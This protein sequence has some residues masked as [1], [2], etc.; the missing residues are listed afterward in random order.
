MDKT[1]RLLRSRVWFPGMDKAVENSIQRCRACSLTA[2]PTPPEPIASTPFPKRQ[3]DRLAIDFHGP[4]ANGHELMAIIDEATKFPIVVEV[5]STAFQ[6]IKPRLDDLFSLMGYPSTIKSDNGPPFMGHDF[7]DYLTN[8]G[9]KHRKIT[10]YH[11]QANGQVEN[12]N[13]NLKKIIQRSFVSN[14]DWHEELNAFL[15]GYRATPHDSTGV[16][17]ADLIFINPNHSKLPPKF[18]SH[19]ADDLLALAA[20]NDTATK[21]KAKLYADK[22]RRSRRHELA[23]GDKVVIDQRRG[24]KLYNAKDSWFAPEHLTITAFKGSMVTVQ[25]RT[26]RNI[27][28]NNSYF[29][30]MGADG[31]TDWDIPM[32]RTNPQVPIHGQPEPLDDLSRSFEPSEPPMQAPDAPP[33]RRSARETRPPTAMWQAQR[34]ALSTARQEVN[35]IKRD[36]RSHFFSPPGRCNQSAPSASAQQIWL[37][38]TTYTNTQALCQR[39]QPFDT[40]TIINSVLSALVQTDPLINFKPLNL[41]DSF[42]GLSS[43]AFIR[44]IK[45]D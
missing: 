9:I 4:L 13:K 19:T 44:P 45:F 32:V 5:A 20:K 35:A 40:R 2:P 26:G 33:P 42:L 10:P 27:T 6:T 24:K 30:R 36:H 25:D 34:P 28:R 3:W 37:P 8:C 14:S 11:P 21:L 7:A 16:P 43:L 41:S 23:A 12:F 17:P 22:G 18:R 38:K 31:N 39:P 29:K 15:R 1:K